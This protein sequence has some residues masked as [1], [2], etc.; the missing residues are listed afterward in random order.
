LTE[1]LYLFDHYLKEFDASIIEIPDS[2]SIVLDRTAIYPRGG[3]QPSDKGKIVRAND[4]FTMEVAEAAKEEGKVIHKFSLPLDE[5]KRQTLLGSKVHG[6]I[7][8]EL[9]YRHMRHHTALHI[10]SGVVFL[11]FN[12]RITGGQIYPERARLDLALSDLSKERQSI[13]EEEMNKIVTEDH[14]VKTVWLDRE[15]ALKRSELYRLTG[16]MLPKGVEKLRLVDI[17]GFDAQLDGGTHVAHTREIGKIKISKTENKGKD[18]KRI[19]I[20]LI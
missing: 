8:W 1:L 4:G 6:T 13:I 10:L 2:N 20:V 16:D 12:A 11:K 9:R 17:V 3:G 19:E 7:D 14:E 15:E 5:T 18:N